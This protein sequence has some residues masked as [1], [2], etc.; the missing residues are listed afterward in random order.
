MYK[1]YINNR[2]NAWERILSHH[3][4][5]NQR[6][7]NPVII[8]GHLLYNKPDF[9]RL[10]AAELRLPLGINPFTIKLNPKKVQDPK[11]AADSKKSAQ[12]IKTGLQL[13]KRLRNAFAS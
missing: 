9:N 8:N 7:V 13:E 10:Y 5:N 4:I 2:Y 11:P 3:I 6:C 1:D 12:N